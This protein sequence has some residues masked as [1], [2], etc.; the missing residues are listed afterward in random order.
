MKMMFKL[1]ATTLF[2]K[3]S[4]KIHGGDT[5][6]LVTWSTTSDEAGTY[7]FTDMPATTFDARVDSEDHYTH[8]AD[9][10]DFIA[11]HEFVLNSVTEDNNQNINVKDSSDNII[12][13]AV[14]FMYEEST[15]TWT[16]AT[17]FGG[18]TYVLSPDTG[19]TVYVYVYH[20]YHKP[21][22]TSYQM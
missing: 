13:D 12:S 1:G 9:S 7:Q 4:T 20:E 3:P 2:S 11:P 19:S 10:V 22:V 21:A 14:V 16:D 15:S 17:K 5:V 8:N 6:T 18:A